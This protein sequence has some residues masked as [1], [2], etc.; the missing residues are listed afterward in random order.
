MV[1]N[2]PDSRAK[3]CAGNLPDGTVFLVNNPGR[4]T[5]DDNK[6][7]KTKSDWA[8]YRKQQ[9]ETAKTQEAQRQAARERKTKNDL[10]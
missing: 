7:W 4:V 6:T 10:Y 5:N 9:E 1:T 3:Q 8:E 2:M